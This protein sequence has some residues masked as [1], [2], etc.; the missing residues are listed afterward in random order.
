MIKIDIDMSNFAVMILL[1][2][3][4]CT[5]IILGIQGFI[6]KDSILRHTQYYK[7]ESVVAILM[8]LIVFIGFLITMYRS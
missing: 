7:M 3:A 2:I 8:G 6:Y 4:S 5:S 1:A